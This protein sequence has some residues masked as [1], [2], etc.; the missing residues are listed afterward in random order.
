MSLFSLEQALVN[1]VQA[2]YPSSICFA[3][4]QP[5]SIAEQMRF[6]S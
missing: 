4:K 5:D 6:E 1:I 2:S 3:E